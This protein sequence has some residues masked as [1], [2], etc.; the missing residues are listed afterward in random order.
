MV[1]YNLIVVFYLGKLQFLG[2]LHFTKYRDCASLKPSNYT[3]LW[4]FTGLVIKTKNW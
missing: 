4:V 2:Y 1:D 3:V